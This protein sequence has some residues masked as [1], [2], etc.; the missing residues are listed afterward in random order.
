MGR[1]AGVERDGEGLQ[2]AFD[3]IR[4]YS[5]YVMNHQFDD[6]AGWELQNLLTSAAVMV[7][8]AMVRT[9]SRGVHFRSDYPNPDDDQ[10]RRRLTVQINVDGGYPQRGPL[11]EPA[12]A[13]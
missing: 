10:W 6:V 8:S 2:K 9:E 4:S 5:A 7:S 12:P 1:L 13:V 11:L 3:S